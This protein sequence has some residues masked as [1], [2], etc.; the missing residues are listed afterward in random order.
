MYR[1]AAIYLTRDQV[2]G[3]ASSQHAPGMLTAQ[4]APYRTDLRC[5]HCE[6]GVRHRVTLTAEPLGV[7]E[8]ALAGGPLEVAEHAFFAI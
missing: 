5:R 2:A 3:L 4:V 1:R 6:E 8:P 7:A